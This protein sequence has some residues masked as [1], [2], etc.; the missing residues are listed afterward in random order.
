MMG[1]VP[2]LNPVKPPTVET[3]WHLDSASPPVLGTLNA[4]ETCW[5]PR[6]ATGVPVGWPGNVAGLIELEALEKAPEP[7]LF[8][9]PQVS[10]NGSKQHATKSVAYVFV[11]LTRT[12][13]NTPLV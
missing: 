4:T 6:D 2:K 13:T 7:T 1:L 5:L 3:A 11:Q 12:V 9:A 10:Y 8:A